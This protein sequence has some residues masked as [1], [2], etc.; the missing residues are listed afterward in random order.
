MVDV[1]VSYKREDA[2]AVG[3]LVEA[4]RAQGLG[5]WWDADIPAG[6]PWETTIEG[7]L[8][9]ARAVVVCWSAASTASENVKAEARWARE[10]G[11][12]LQ[13]FLD[14]SAPPLFFGERQG[15]DLD[16]WSGRADDPRIAGVVESVRAI[17]EGRP[18][19][20]AARSGGPRRRPWW[21]YAAV[22]AALLIPV[23]GAGVAL[24]GSPDR[25]QRTAPAAVRAPSVDPALAALAGDWGPPAAPASIATRWRA[26]ASG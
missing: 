8:A 11:R 20:P 5:V 25:P 19:E 1:F 21:L 22:G 23:V 12:L 4:L 26:I 3:R 13:L 2:R 6:A 14:G 7:K 9:D 17:L 16:G 15:I 18:A 10:R 24:R